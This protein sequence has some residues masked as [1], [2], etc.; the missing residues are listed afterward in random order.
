[1]SIKMAMKS[2]NEVHNENTMTMEMKMTMQLDMT[3]KW[4]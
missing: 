3:T 4:Q 1:M 2:G